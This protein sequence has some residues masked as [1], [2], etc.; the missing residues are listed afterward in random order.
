MHVQ[1][2]LPPRVSTSLLLR[3]RPFRDL[4]A[5]GPRNRPR[6]HS[7]DYG[8]TRWRLSRALPLPCWLVTV[9][10][11]TLEALADG[12]RVMGGV[13]L[14]A[15]HRRNNGVPQEQARMLGLEHTKKERPWS[16]Q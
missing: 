8:E 6:K 14:R 10:Q 16:E 15:H 11:V 3:H 1:A 12:N 4:P 5:H 2:A 9:P 7:P 13:R